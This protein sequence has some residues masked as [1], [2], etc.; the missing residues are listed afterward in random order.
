MAQPISLP[1]DEYGKPAR[2]SCRPLRVALSLT[3]IALTLFALVHSFFASP[4]PTP[5]SASTTKHVLPTGWYARTIGHPAKDSFAPSRSALSF[6]LLESTPVNPEGFI[7]AFFSPDF[8]VDG[9]GHV[10]QVSKDDLP[11]LTTLAQRATDETSVPQPGGFRN[12]W[13]IR[14]DRTDYPIDWLRVA[15][16]AQGELKGVSV[17]GFD[18]THD[19]LSPPV[20]SVDRLPSVLMDA[21]NV[22]GEGRQGFDNGDQDPDM[23]ERTK[24]VVNAE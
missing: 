19:E 6:A 5:M 20:G 9:A 4:A 15:T 18:G 14:Q 7:A 22:F 1:F 10:R 24:L 23:I 8:V 13:R 11:A 12:Q 3:I 2:R 17:Y 21:F 16:D